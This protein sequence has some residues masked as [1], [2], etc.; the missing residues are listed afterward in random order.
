MGYGKVGREASFQ[1]NKESSPFS[2]EIGN[3]NQENR[4]FRSEEKEL[5]EKLVKRV[6]A[7][8]V[9]KESL[10]ERDDVKS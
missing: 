6:K 4:V 2:W 5:D 7:F 8:P 1:L 3:G 10:C 9:W